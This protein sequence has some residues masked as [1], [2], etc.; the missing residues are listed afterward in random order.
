MRYEGLCVGRPPGGVE[1]VEAP[2]DILAVSGPHVF[3]GVNAEPGHAYV[4]QVVH[5]ASH[6]AVIP[7][8]DRQQMYVADS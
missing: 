8:Y 1:V 6:L 5:V 3:T 4:D 7:E 2:P